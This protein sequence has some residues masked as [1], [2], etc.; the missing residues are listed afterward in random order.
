MTETRKIT[1]SF[2]L[3]GRKHENVEVLN[4][5]DWFGKT[6]V[7]YVEDCFDPPM[8]VVEADNV[9]DAQDEFVDSGRGHMVEID[10]AN[11][12]DYGVNTDDPTCTFAGNNDKPCDTESLMIHGDDRTGYPVLYHVEGLADPVKPAEYSDIINGLETREQG[13]YDAT[14]R[15]PGEFAGCAPYVPYLWENW[16]TGDYVDDSCNVLRYEITAEDRHVFPELRGVEFVYL[17]RDDNGAF[18]GEVNAPGGQ[19]SVDTSTDD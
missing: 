11:Y 19:D 10:P 7:L 18:A 14:V 8:F 4:P 15:Q 9:S 12:D 1:A 5:G 16:F 17:R 13:G 2:T 6:W 3:H